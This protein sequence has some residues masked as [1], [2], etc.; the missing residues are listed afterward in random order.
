MRRGNCVRM[1]DALPGRSARPC[2]QATP[3]PSGAAEPAPFRLVRPELV[4]KKAEMAW[5][6][7]AVPDADSWMSKGCRARLHGLSASQQGRRVVYAAL[8]KRN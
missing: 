5:K 1:H 6:H 3:P 4:P 7:V 8:L 2:S